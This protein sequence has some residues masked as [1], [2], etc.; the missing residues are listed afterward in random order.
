MCSG[1]S[2]SSS[3]G[4]RLLRRKQMHEVKVFGQKGAE[5]IK[6][7]GD[8]PFQWRGEYKLYVWKP[9]GRAVWVDKRDVPALIKAVGVEN[10]KGRNLD[11]Y[12]ERKASRKKPAKPRRV[13]GEAEPEPEP[14]AE[15]MEEETKGPEP[16]KES[17]TEEK[18]E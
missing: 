11:A 1:C 7:L 13:T 16:E 9:N 8:K 18:E 14:A 6:Y 12:R 15:E 2:S 17:P 10:L 4:A 5:G 3:G